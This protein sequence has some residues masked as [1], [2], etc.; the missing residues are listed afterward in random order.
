MGN[1]KKF[2]TKAINLSKRFLKISQKAKKAKK[3]QQM[4]NKSVYI[5]SFFL[6]HFDIKPLS[7]A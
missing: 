7:S 5:I 4:N 1:E 6:S 3:Q 2:Y